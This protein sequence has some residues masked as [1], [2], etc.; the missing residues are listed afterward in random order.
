MK[1]WHRGVL[2]VAATVGLFFSLAGCGG[3]S[4]IIPDSGSGADLV[5]FGHATLTPSVAHPWAVETVEGGPTSIGWTTSI[6]TGTPDETTPVRISYY[7]YIAKDL[8]MASGSLGGPWTLATRDAPFDVGKYNS[9]VW[10]GESAPSISYYDAYGRLKADVGGTPGVADPQKDLGAFNDIVRGSGATLHVAYTGT[11]TITGLNKRSQ[12]RSAFFDGST[13]TSEVIEDAPATAGSFWFSSI[14]KASPL[15]Y[16]I[17]YKGQNGRL[18]MATG[19]TGVWST[20]EVLPGDPMT[21]N[22]GQTSDLVAAD[23]TV[24]VFYSKAGTGGG[25]FHAWKAGGS[26][27]AELVA[28]GYGIMTPSAAVEDLTG[29]MRVAAYKSDTKDLAVFTSGSW[30]AEIVDS[31]GDVGQYAAIAVDPQNCIHISYVNNTAHDLKYATKCPAN[32]PPLILSISA[33]PGTINEGGTSNLAVTATDPDGDPLTYAWTLDVPASPAGSYGSPASSS[34]PWVAPPIPSGPV[35]FTLRATVCDPLAACATTTVDVTVTNMFDGPATGTTG[36]AAG[37]NCASGGLPLVAFVPEPPA[38]TIIPL[39]TRDEALYNSVK[40]GPQGPVVSAPSFASPSGSGFLT[41][42]N[43]GGVPPLGTS[44]QGL[45]YTGLRPPDPH[46][47]AGPSH[48]IPIVNSKFG[49]F[50]K[51]GT[52]LF[53]TTGASWFSPVNSIGFIFD[54]KVN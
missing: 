16:D 23:G 36:S 8:K 19:N 32:R 37:V 22:V 30:T 40:S 9:L 54:P 6:A 46:I 25:L 28:S 17:S 41:P 49:I 1:N 52:K 53:E 26:W 50:N 45:T 47:A 7:D 31:A 44:F 35:Y 14:D 12:L 27:S 48:I 29:K 39:M 33:N 21:S 10:D 2:P 24:H 11:I 20:E 18:K 42:A 13:W 4:G 15:L 51:T 5:D 38:E 43:G 3:G 34:T